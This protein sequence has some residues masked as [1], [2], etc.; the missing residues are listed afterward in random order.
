VKIKTHGI[1]E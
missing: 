1:Q